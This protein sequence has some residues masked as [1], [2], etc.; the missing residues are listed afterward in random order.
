[1]HSAWSIPFAIQTL[2]F[3]T[4]DPCRLT[5][6]YCFFYLQTGLHTKY[7]AR[8]NSEPELSDLMNEIA[9]KIPGKWRDIGLQL[10]L[11]P[12]VLDGIALISPGDINHCYSNVFTR[13]KNLNSTTHP[14]TW[15]TV[16]Q[17]LESETVAE[18]LL[19]SKIKNELTGHP[20][21]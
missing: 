19:A 17:A 10:E 4:L 7:P 8:L 1:M 15:S 18:K 13:W 6:D 9:A 16:V 2:L 21:Q 12:G 20:P 5:S 14:Y 11:E 3:L